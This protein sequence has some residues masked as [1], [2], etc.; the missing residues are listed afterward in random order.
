M[1]QVGG[2]DEFTRNMQIVVSFG[3]GGGYDLWARAVAGHMSQ[4]LAG[5]PSI[6]VQNMP[7]AGGFTAAN[8]LYNLAPKDGSV[9]GLVAREAP[10]GPLTG[11]EGARFDS[12]KFSW[13]GTPTVET[14]VCIANTS[15]QAKFYRD[16][17]GEA[18]VFGDTG[19]GSG[20]F[21]YS[22]AH[23]ALLDF[24]IRFVSGFPSTSDIFLAMERREV[25]G[26]C[27]GIDSIV[28]RRPEWIEARKVAVLSQSGRERHR[29]L[30]DVPTI[31]E[32][33]K[34]DDARK[35]L[36]FIYAGQDIGRPFIAP[37]DLP[38][39]RLAQLRAAFDATMKNPAFIAAAAAQKLATEPKGGAELEKLIKAL[40][41]TPPAIRKEAAEI[42]K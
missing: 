28:S 40:Y 22:R 29:N 31:Y 21:A 20:T 14:S 39:G 38:P 35:V 19:S 5:K 32:L 16:G 7:G 10:L 34:N 37:P 13:I 26:V 30:Q 25:D 2:G 18:L 17:K 42:M 1:A 6:V 4:Y 36:A 11:A 41:Q 24:K 9:I 8:Y 27:E 12:T 33:A 23:A 15:S 3:S